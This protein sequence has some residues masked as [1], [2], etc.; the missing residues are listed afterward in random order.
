MRQPANLRG[1]T[2]PGLS[3]P[4]EK[5]GPHHRSFWL[6]RLQRQA[7]SLALSGRGG[8]GPLRLKQQ[9]AAP[10]TFS[11][12]EQLPARCRSRP[13]GLLAPCV[14]VGW[15]CWFSRGIESRC[16][17]C[18]L[19]SQEPDIWTAQAAWLCA[20]LEVTSVSASWGLTE[21][22]WAWQEVTDLREIPQVYHFFLSSGPGC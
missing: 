9:S 22:T 10:L 15:A 18:L 2:L 1:A 6:P 16:G 12:R 7:D 13:A 3:Q 21:Q 11:Q 5:E 14:T 4:S 17:S 19:L 8:A 20:A